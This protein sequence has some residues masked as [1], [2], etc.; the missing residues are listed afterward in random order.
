MKIP[1]ETISYEDVELQADLTYVEEPSKI[2]A[3]TGNNFATEPL[4]IARCNGN[5]TRK[6]KLPRRRKKT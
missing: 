3:K 4:N 1:E 2:L 5:I 6:E